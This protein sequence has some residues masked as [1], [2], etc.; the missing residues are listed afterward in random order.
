RNASEAA[1]KVVAV[2][3][4]AGSGYVELTFRDAGQGMKIEVMRRAFGPFFTTRRHR[5]HLAWAYSKPGETWRA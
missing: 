5:E 3:A 2:T 1:A 4:K